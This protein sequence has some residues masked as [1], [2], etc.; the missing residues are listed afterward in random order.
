MKMKTCS[1][2]GEEKHFNR[3]SN[4]NQIPVRMACLLELKLGNYSTLLKTDFY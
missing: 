1:L 2:F 3:V 4:K